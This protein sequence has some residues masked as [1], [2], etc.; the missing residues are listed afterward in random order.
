MSIKRLNPCAVLAGSA[1]YFLQK[2]F[3]WLLRH[4]EFAAFNGQH[5]KSVFLQAAMVLG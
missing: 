2:N 4:D 5:L 3:F 1:F